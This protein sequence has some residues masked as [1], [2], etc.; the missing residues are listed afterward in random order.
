M[1][2]CSIQGSCRKVACLPKR[3]VTNHSDS[4]QAL[5]K[6]TFKKRRSEEIWDAS[7]LN[8]NNALLGQSLENLVATYEIVWS[9][10]QAQ[11][12]VGLA[13]AVE[14]QETSD[15]SAQGDLATQPYLLAAS[16]G[17]ED[18]WSAETFPGIPT[19]ALLPT[20]N[21][22]DTSPLPSSSS[23]KRDFGEAFSQL[24][25]QES[26][27]VECTNSEEVEKCELDTQEMHRA[28]GDEPVIGQD[29]PGF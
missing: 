25:F 7:V 24:D 28:L 9:R 15:A 18:T 26:F 10:P 4:C 6:Q 14:V 17:I 29:S 5:L 2:Q 3:P 11:L 23:R 21:Y 1:F 19:S 12:M 22:V 13:L 20:Q 27:L 16:A 8:G